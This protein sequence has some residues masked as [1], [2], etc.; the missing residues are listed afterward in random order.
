MSSSASTQVPQFETPTA[1]GIIIL[2]ML[3]AVS[4]VFLLG[5]IVVMIRF[6]H[7]EDKNEWISSKI[8]VI[9]GMLIIE[10]IIVGQ[11]IDVANNGGSDDCSYGWGDKARCGQLDMDVFWNV[12]FGL[13]IF[14]II[15]VIPWAVFAYEAFD[16]DKDA[17]M[18]SPVCAALR[19]ELMILAAVAVV[20][21][22]D[23]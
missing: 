23:E 22:D 20:V 9:F 10:L 2:F 15:L 8:V 6:Q 19:Y 12:I 3:A 16:D 14:W 4:V 21:G 7:P 18:Q 1:G 17:S 11:P 5:N 13:T